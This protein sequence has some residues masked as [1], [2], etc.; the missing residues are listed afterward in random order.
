M[1]Q[2]LPIWLLALLVIYA[3]VKAAYLDRKGLPP[4]PIA[5]P[6][7]GSGLSLDVKDFKGSIAKLIKRFWSLVLTGAL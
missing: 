2:G 4:G 6:I 5:L 7:I 1:G 3:F